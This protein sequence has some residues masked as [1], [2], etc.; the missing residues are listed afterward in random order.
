MDDFDSAGIATRGLVA[1]SLVQ[2]HHA[3]LRLN[4]TEEATSESQ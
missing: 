3:Y 4:A 2:A 1:I